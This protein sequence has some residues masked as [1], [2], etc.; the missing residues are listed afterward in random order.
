[1]RL[2]YSAEHMFRADNGGANPKFGLDA[3]EQHCNL[4]TGDFD[5]NGDG[6]Y[7]PF[8]DVCD[9]F[10]ALGGPKEWLLVGEVNGAVA[11]YGHMDL[12]IG[13]RAPTEVWPRVLDFLERHP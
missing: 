13:E 4:W 5:V 3:V 7:E 12:V 6:T 11:D 9:G 10:R 8:D 1:M 2:F